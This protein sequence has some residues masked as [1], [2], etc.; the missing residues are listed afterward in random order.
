[1]IAPLRRRHRTLFVVLSLAVPAL[2]LVALAHRPPAP[3]VPE[4]PPEFASGGAEAGE[5]L[6]LFAGYAALRTV[7]GGG[8]HLTL[9]ALEPLRRPGV[10][11]YVS[12]DAPTDQLPTDAHLLGPVT[13]GQARTFTLPPAAVHGGHLVLYSLPHQEIVDTAALPG[14]NLPAE[15]EAGTAVNRTDPAGEE[16]PAD[17]TQTD[18]EKHP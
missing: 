10:L 8:A 15:G 12:T 3:Q 1:M 13:W 14:F 16:R 9:E 7:N 11:A 6:E 2:F 4:L 5:R 17:E 18:E